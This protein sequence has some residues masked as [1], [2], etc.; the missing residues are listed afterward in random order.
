MLEVS[1]PL[2]QYNFFCLFL[3]VEEENIINNFLGG[4]GVGMGILLVGLSI[5][6]RGSHRGAFK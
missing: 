6:V 1:F 3:F 2:F 5:F 4:F